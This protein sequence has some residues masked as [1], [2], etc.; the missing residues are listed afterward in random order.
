LF[1]ATADAQICAKEEADA[2]SSDDELGINY[3]RSSN[4]AN[5]RKRRAVFD[6]S[7][8]EENVVSIASPERPAQLAPNP[9][10]E[11]P[12]D[13]KENQ[14]KLESKQD[15]QSIVKDCIKE[16]DSDIFSE[17]NKAKNG[18][19][20]KHSGITLK[21]K[22]SDPPINN[23]KQDQPPELAS[24]SPKRRKVLK[25]RINERGREGVVVL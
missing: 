16:M 13:T 23:S 21:E 6:F 10:T 24:T 18:S 8:D 1:S 12:E 3:K 15:K 25:T 2:D 4:G 14:K 11:A 19:T 17:H 22:S 20:I 9:V 7:D 5:N